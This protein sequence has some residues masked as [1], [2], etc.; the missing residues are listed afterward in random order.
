LPKQKDEKDD[1]LVGNEVDAF[2]ADDDR[3]FGS[4]TEDAKVINIDAALHLFDHLLCLC[5]HL[6]TFSPESLLSRLAE[7]AVKSSTEAAS[8]CAAQAAA[9]KAPP[10]TGVSRPAAK[11]AAAKAPPTT[12]VSRPAAK[13]AAA[14]APP[15]SV[16][17]R[18]A[19]KGALVLARSR[20]KAGAESSAQAASMVAAKGALVPGGMRD[21]GGGRSGAAS[22]AVDGAI[23]ISDDNSDEFMQ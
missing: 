16:Y 19:A 23:R 1:G 2:V 22:A 8:T 20:A 21:R 9:A 15:T 12:G 17:A 13:A 4:R 14:K 6:S 11:A 5:N 10:T 18:S 3:A 7:A